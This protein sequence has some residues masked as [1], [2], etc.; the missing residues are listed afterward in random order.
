LSE[1]ILTG[2]LLIL[3]AVYITQTEISTRGHNHCI[4]LSG[5]YK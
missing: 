1:V 2:P 5:A 4:L 3:N